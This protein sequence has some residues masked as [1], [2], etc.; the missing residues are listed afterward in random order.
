MMSVGP[1]GE[2]GTI[3][4][5]ACAGY[6]LP[7]WAA[8][9]CARS[10]PASTSAAA[11]NSRR[12]LLFMHS[13]LDF[14]VMLPL[15]SRLGQLTKRLILHRQR[16]PPRLAVCE[17]S[18]FTTK[19][20]NGHTDDRSAA[21]S[22]P[23]LKPMGLMQVLAPLLAAL[24][25]VVLALLAAWALIQGAAAQDAKETI[26]DLASYAGADRIEKLLGG[27]EKEGSVSLYSSAAPEDLAALP[28]ALQQQY[29]VQPRL[30][31]GRSRQVV[32]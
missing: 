20:A 5:T 26:E 8:A 24:L 21:V 2:N 11:K 30:R 14:S 19:F 28:R 15:L 9:L 29:A 25:A 7:D 17:A 31:R 1:A 3:T 10:K 4:L 18:G 27:A 6:S 22:T 23:R 16:S 13:S 12:A 32:H